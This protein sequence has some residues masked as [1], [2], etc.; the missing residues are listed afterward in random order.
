MS[1]DLINTYFPAA[2]ELTDAQLQ[3]MRDRLV[4]YGAVKFPDLDM[5]PDS[6]FGNYILNPLAFMLAGTEEALR[7]QR[8]D[9]DTEQIAGGVI[10]DCD[11]VEAF[12]K[13]WAVQDRAIK[14]ASGTIRLVCSSDELIE[15]DRGTRFSFATDTTTSVFMIRLAHP[16][17]LQLLP[18]GSDVQPGQNQLVFQQ[19]ASALYAVD[20]PVLGQMAAAGVTQ[21]LAATLD[22]TV[23]NLVSAS[24][25]YDFYQGAPTLTLPQMAQQARQTAYAVGLGSRGQSVQMIR[26]NFPEAIGCSAVMS[27]DVESMRGG[28]NALGIK[29]GAL[30]LFVKSGTYQFKDTAYLKVPWVIEQNG[31]TVNRFITKLDL[32]HTPVRITGVTHSSGVNL[33]YEIIGQAKDPARASLLTA[34][35]S[36]L[37]DLWL[38]IE[39]PNQDGSDLI[40]L[41]VNADGT[42]H[43]VFQVEYWTDP[44]IANASRF[45]DGDEVV[46]ENCDLVV[47]GFLPLVFSQFDIQYV[48]A[49]GVLMTLEQA[50]RDIAAYL[51]SIVYPDGY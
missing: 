44:L 38:V 11:F 33:S 26:Q 2:S 31:D 3:S 8:S 7:R 49:A 15:L 36:E 34:G 30:D 35:F 22:R 23:T 28:M 16:G 50:R 5:R 37:E 13:N 46:A 51:N 6:V 10:Y 9:L 14:Q 32:L 25:L 21:G 20:I 39:M 29:R 45:V 18:V 48:R 24:A 42:S 17:L 41:T 19:I 40:P 43:A 4:T 27:D 1:F 47:R 12:L